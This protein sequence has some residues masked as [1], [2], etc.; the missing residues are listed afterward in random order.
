MKLKLTLMIIVIF[1][2]NY[3][4]ASIKVIKTNRAS[5]EE[6]ASQP[7]DDSYITTLD[8][9]SMFEKVTG[10]YD[11]ELDFINDLDEEALANKDVP[12]P[13]NKITSSDIDIDIID[14]D[15][16]DN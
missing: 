3:A 5:V 14:S 1:S 10:S 13:K 11:E 16:F 2:L 15:L 8:E 12:D 9:N 6:D 4:S 7:I